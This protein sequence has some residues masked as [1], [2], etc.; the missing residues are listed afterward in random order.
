M[1]KVLVL[2]GFFLCCSLCVMAQTNRERAV[3][4]L[5]WVKQ[6]QTDSVYA[7]LDFNTRKMIQKSQLEGMWQQLVQQVG[8]VDSEGEWMQDAVQGIILYY[9]DINFK[10]MPL[11]FVVSFD[12]DGQVNKLR[13]VPVPAAVKPVEAVFDSVRL[14][15]RAMEVVTGEYHLPAT[16]TF[17]RDG[18]NLPLVILVQG[19]GP[20]DRDGSI[21]PNKV[22]RD[23]AWG[24]AEKGIAVLRFDKRTYIY[25]DKSVPKG[26][27]I[28]P[29]E[30]VIDDVLSAIR[31]AGNI[32]EVDTK[33]VFVAGHSLGGL[34]APQ[35]AKEADCLKGVIM[36]AASCRPLDKVMEEQIRYIASLEG[37]VTEEQIR[38]QIEQSKKMAPQAYWKWLQSYEP[39]MTAYGL[40]LPMLFLQGERDY[41]VTM[42]DFAMWKLGLFGKPNATFKSYPPL[43]HCF[44]EGEGKSTPMEYN[45]PA[46]VSQ[47]VIED[48]ADWILKN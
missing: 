31:L 24:L 43:N 10:R 34:L 21:G 5:E 9:K 4:L 23:L 3:K 36:L 40:T 33:R 26:M 28:T 35:I 12:A 8:E 42:Q 18:N 47:S 11:R 16:L 32:K 38:Q 46:R 45:H 20:H 15:E 29:K 7:H 44:M 19:S 22:Y 6:N 30:E 37:G 1:K 39:V 48:V 41:Q 2:I 27:E 17:P 13:F 14:E 25:K